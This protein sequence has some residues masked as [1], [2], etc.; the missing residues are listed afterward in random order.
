MKIEQTRPDKPNFKLIVVFASVTL[1]VILALALVFVRFD[2]KHLVFR[3]HSPEPNSNLVMPTG[4]V[5]VLK[6]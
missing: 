4:G 3:H 1:L 2:G 5:T 6:A